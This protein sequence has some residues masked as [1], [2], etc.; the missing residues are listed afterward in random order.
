MKYELKGR[1]VMGR[2]IG[3]KSED[4]HHA[5]SRP[6]NPTGLA[7]VESSRKACPD[8]CSSV[9]VRPTLF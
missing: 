5:L 2:R 4:P 1:N 6:V 9:L 7:V 8:L 3:Q